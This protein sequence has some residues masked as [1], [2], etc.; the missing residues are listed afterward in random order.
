MTGAHR[1]PL[2]VT[3]VLAVGAA[4]GAERWLLDLAAAGSRLQVSWVALADGPL[5]AELRAR[6]DRVVVL[7]TGRR[8]QDLLG[9]VV[10]LAAALR[11][12]RPD[13]VVGNGVKAALVAVAAGRLAGV[14]TVWVK[15][16]HSFDG[17]LAQLL[18]GAAD[19]VVATSEPL[20][21]SVAPARVAVVV[22]PPRPDPPLSR[23]LARKQLAERG[24][25]WADDRLTLVCAS[26][27][28]P[29][30]G[31]DDAIRALALPPARD[32][33]LV[34][35]GEDDAATP[36]ERERL[37]ALAAGLGLQDRV[38][39]PGAVPG[40]GRLL[41]AGDAVAVLTR[42]DVAGTP[43]SE[44]FG[45]A[46]LEAQLAGLPVIATAAVPAAAASP[47]SVWTVAPGSPSAVA[48]AL[49]ELS[50]ASVRARA[51]ATALAHARAAP[52]RGKQADLLARTLA[53]T[54]GRPGSG[55]APE[56]SLS[57]V[58]TVFNDREPTR[59]MLAA[60]LPQ[61]RP[62]D[63]LVV[64]DAGSTDGTTEVLAEAAA[65]DPRVRVLVRPGAGISAGRNTGIGAARHAWLACT[66]A[67]CTAAPGWLD[68]FR[69]A[70][71]DTH[72]DAL[73]TGVYAVTAVGP[74]QRALA[75]VGYPAPS[76]ARHPGPL[77]RTYGR[78]FGRVVDPSLPTGRSVAFSRAVWT[79]AGG[80][81]EHLQTGEDVLFGRAA[82]AAGHPALLVTDAEVS[83][84][85]RASLRQTARM[86]HSYGYGDG[87]SG[88]RQL[89]GRDLARLVA[90]AGGLATLALGGRRMR[91]SAAAAG[92]AYLSLPLAR[93]RGDLPTALLVPAAAAL[94]DLAKVAGC[95]AGL[96]AAR[97]G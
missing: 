80:F 97:R 40:A 75:A 88:S 66:D 25:D 2:R 60:L 62:D 64:V 16:D 76:E 55:L 45:L 38:C 39:L 3:A 37:R 91:L 47:G 52:D 8:P 57:V 36:G 78:L 77:V 74:V 69:S 92:A 18:A 53:R 31:V 70:A 6:G 17:R 89:V 56:N 30:K 73:L 24:V 65:G 4:G 87:L 67:G 49:G 19:A 26:R 86:Y 85:Q 12:D 32:W 22:Q 81:P 63:E 14:R 9:P 58:S 82:V 42:P 72:G 29:Y 90:Y 51:G 13:V 43:G 5:V 94:R 79:D 93:T 46:A 50:D 15:H 7:A 21:A 84:E 23:A 71:V 59:A 33:R 83:W 28:V 68:A 11:R 54:A 44:G 35:L 96:R 34:V 48:A 1:P 27:L 10:R 20:A 41:A 61:L 95:L